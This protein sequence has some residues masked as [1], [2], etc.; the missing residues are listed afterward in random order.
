MP[1]GPEIRQAAD[2]IAAVLEG[3]VIEAATLE[4]ESLR[5]AARHIVGHKV[6]QVDCHGKALLTRFSSGKTIYSHNQLYG[7]WM[8][9]ERDVIPVTNRALRIGLHTKTHSA[10]LFSA[11][12]I[13]LWDTAEVHQHPFLKKLGPDVLAASTDVDALLGQ[14]SNFKNRSLAALYLDQGFIAGLGNYLRSE[15]LF[16]AGVHPSQKPAQMDEKSLCKLARVTLEISRRSYQTRG[17]TL[18]PKLMP[19]ARK[20][21]GRVYEGDRFAVFARAGKACRI[22]KTK[23]VKAAMNSRRIYWCPSCQPPVTV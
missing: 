6:E 15:I 11:T 2:Q 16:F 3:Q 19:K 7:V 14:L 8:V 20:R 10:L 4:H 1:E 18:P 5:H 9:M 21:G 13:S 22:C 17:Q 23:V 12:D